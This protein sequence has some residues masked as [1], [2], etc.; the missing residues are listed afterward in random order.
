MVSITECKSYEQAEV[1]QAL[2]ELLQ[3]LGGLDWVTPDM[4]VGI[5]VNLITMIKPEAAATR[6]C[7]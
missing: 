2:T 1:R 7:Y 4:T 5:K 6:G 3:P